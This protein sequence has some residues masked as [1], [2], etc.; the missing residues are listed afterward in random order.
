LDW[1]DWINKKVFIQ[2]ETSKYFGTVV[3][4]TDSGNGL[5]WIGFYSNNNFVLLRVD[6]IKKIEELT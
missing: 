1:K 5:I 2:T 4:V 6:E 3:E